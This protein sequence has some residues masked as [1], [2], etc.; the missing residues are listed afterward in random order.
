MIGEILLDHVA[1]IAEAD[2]EVSHAIR[3][4]DVHDVPQDRAATDLDHRLWAQMGFFRDA[5]AHAAREDHRLHDTRRTKAF[6]K[7]VT[8]LR[9][10]PSWNGKPGSSSTKFG[11]RARN[12]STAAV[13]LFHVQSGAVRGAPASC[14]MMPSHATMYDPGE[15]MGA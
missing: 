7:W 1:A 14:A 8:R 12:A 4:V 15:T 5:G 9:T 11:L 10:T 6:G 13:G 2:H 3:G